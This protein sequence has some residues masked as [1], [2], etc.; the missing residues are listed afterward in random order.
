MKKP[1]TLQEASLNLRASMGYFGAAALLAA[2][3]QTTSSTI[4]E[5]ARAQELD[6]FRA[7]CAA[8]QADPEP[9]IELAKASSLPLDRFLAQEWLR[10]VRDG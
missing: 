5:W 6:A 10:L 7:R 4:Y 3:A 9:S 1:M 8:I 2:R